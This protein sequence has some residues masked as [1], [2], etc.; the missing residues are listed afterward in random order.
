MFFNAVI[1]LPL[2]EDGEWGLEWS[3]GALIVA[4]NPGRAH[5]GEWALDRLYGAFGCSQFPPAEL[6]KPYLNNI[7]GYPG[8]Y[9]VGSPP[10][11]SHWESCG[12]V[13]ERGGTTLLLLPIWLLMSFMLAPGIFLAW[14][15]WVSRARRRTGRCK[16]CGYDLRATP[17]RCPEC[18]TPI[19]DGTT[20]AIGDVT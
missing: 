7:W 11:P 6:H 16:V 18:G 8:I 1:A 10:E 13:L 5:G 15:A 2:N 17:D 19:S 14:L 20:P 3:R 12:V 4:V 9:T